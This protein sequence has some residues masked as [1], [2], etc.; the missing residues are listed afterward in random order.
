MT[1]GRLLGLFLL[2]NLIAEKETRRSGGSRSTW[3][4]ASKGEEE[5]WRGLAS[6]RSHVLERCVG[7]VWW[8]G[9]RRNRSKG[10]RASAPDA[11]CRHV[12]ELESTLSKVTLAKAYGRGLKPTLFRG[13]R[14]A[15]QQH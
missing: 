7:R 6:S 14:R 5:D 4:G 10:A 3:G 12:E 13:R 9:A 8:L 11:D 2:T 1:I 15:P